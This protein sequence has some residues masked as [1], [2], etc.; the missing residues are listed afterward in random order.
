VWTG[1]PISVPQPVGSGRWQV[2]LTTETEGW[3]SAMLAYYPL[4]RAAA[5][6]QTLPTR[7]GSAGELELLLPAGRSLVELSYRPGAI[8]W[9]GLA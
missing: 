1:P 3:V 2:A 6:G 4:W 7:R 5:G 8:E 9:T